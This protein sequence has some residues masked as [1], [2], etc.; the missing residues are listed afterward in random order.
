VPADAILSDCVIYHDAGY[1]KDHE[2]YSGMNSQCAFIIVVQIHP[3]PT[4]RP[5]RRL[6]TD[7]LMDEL[8]GASF[9]WGAGSTDVGDVRERYSRRFAGRTVATSG[10]PRLREGLIRPSAISFGP[11]LREAVWWEVHDSEARAGAL[12]CW[13]SR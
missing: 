3:F 12:A 13:C 4:E 11:H 10:P 1:W 6:A 9:T 8:G 7:A 5:T 2:T